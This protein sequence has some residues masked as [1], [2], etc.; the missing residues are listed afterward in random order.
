MTA[1]SAPIRCGIGGWVFP[2][3][4]D[5]KFYP[6]GLPQREELAYASRALRCIEI[7]G[8]FHRTPTEAQCAKWAAQTPEDFRFSLKAPAIWCS[9]AP[10]PRR[11]RQQRLSCR[12][13][14]HSAS[15]S[16]PCYGSSI[17]AIRPMPRNWRR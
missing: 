15:D 17:R 12:R 7:N 13:Q 1:A 14:S 9:G 8:T 6:V 4:R 2:E 10:C 5:G 11:S 3:W 16:A